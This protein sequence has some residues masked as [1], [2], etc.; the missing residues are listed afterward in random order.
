MPKKPLCSSTGFVSGTLRN[1]NACSLQN[2]YNWHK[3]FF[4]CRIYEKG[5]K[6]CHE[7]WPEVVGSSLDCEEM[8]EVGLAL[9]NVSTQPGKHFTVRTLR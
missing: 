6:K 3:T 1:H 7:Y 9:E 8:L 4:C 5:M 2:D